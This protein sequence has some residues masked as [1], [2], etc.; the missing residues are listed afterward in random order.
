MTAQH[1]LSATPPLVFLD[2]ITHGPNTSQAMLIK[3]GPISALSGGRSV[4]FCSGIGPRS[5]LHV[6]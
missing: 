6:M 3:G 2:C 1:F 4:I 5:V